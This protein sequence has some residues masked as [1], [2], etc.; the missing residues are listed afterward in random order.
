[1]EMYDAAVKVAQRFLFGSQHHAHLAN[2]FELLGLNELAQE[3]RE[4]AEDEFCKHLMID[5]II[6]KQTGRFPN[7][8]MPNLPTISS[9]V[10]HLTPEQIKLNEYE[11]IKK[12][13]DDAQNYEGETMK[14]FEGLKQDI[15]NIK[16]SAF[17]KLVQQLIK[18]VKNEL[19]QITEDRKQL[20]KLG[21][22]KEKIKKG[23]HK[24]RGDYGEN[25]AESR[26]YN[27]GYSR[28]YNDAMADMNKGGQSHYKQP[29]RYEYEDE[30]EEDSY[31]ENRGVGFD[32]RRGVTGTG[33]GRNEMIL[34][35]YMESNDDMEMRRGRRRR[36]RY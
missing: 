3:H 13:F 25:R 1:M 30:E 15:E 2:L 22:D 33:P 27:E 23:E 21:Y 9:Q 29:M 35:P 5:K 11:L 7:Y 18:S 14:L 16:D 12:A 36:Y 32:A 26:N 31:A 6:V 10:A 4:H 17:Q 28:G 20:E 24:M 34:P 19:E 8:G